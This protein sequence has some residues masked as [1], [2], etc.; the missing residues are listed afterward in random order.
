MKQIFFGFTQYLQDYDERFPKAGNFQN[1]SDGGHWVKGG[2]A[3]A[4][5]AAPF[6]P[7]GAKAD[8]G[9]GAL[10][11]Y[12]KSTQIFV[13]PLNRDGRETGLSYSMNCALSGNSQIAVQSDTEIVLLVDEAFPA[14]GYFWADKDATS[15]D[16][17]TQVHNGG[18]NLGFVD[19]HVKFYPF[20]RFPAGDNIGG[21][22]TAIDTKTRTNG[23][24]R[25]FDQDMSECKPLG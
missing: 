21:N 17:L 16:Q 24:P 13:C 23:Q 8:I 12:V 18:G 9:S 22:A 19:G 11:P 14:D 3:I 6:K 20:A 1:W 25:F 4:D 2:G 15:S 7:T 10:F 5:L